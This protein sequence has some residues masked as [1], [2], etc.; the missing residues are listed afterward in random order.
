MQIEV[1]TMRFKLLGPLA[2]AFSIVILPTA[3]HA[4]GPVEVPWSTLLE[5]AFDA[6]RAMG[7]SALAG[8]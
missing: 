4:T 3:A 6:D 1:A 5:R 2:L 7:Q 8:A